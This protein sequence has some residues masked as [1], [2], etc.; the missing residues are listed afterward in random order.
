MAKLGPA[1]NQS[2][3]DSRAQTTDGALDNLTQ[4]VNQMRVDGQQQRGRGRGRGRG[5]GRGGRGDGAHRGGRRQNATQ[6]I[7]VPKEDYDFDAANAKFNKQ[8]LV[9][10]AIATGSPVTSPTKTNGTV[11]NPLENGHANGAEADAEDVVI[12]AASE[13]GYDK[14]SSFFDNISS[15]LKDRIEQQQSEQSFDGRAMRNQERSRNVETFGQ[16]SVDN[17]GYRGSRG[18]G[19]GRG[20]GRGGRGYSGEGQRG[21]R[22]LP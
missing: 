14:K 21:A 17:G 3:N 8:D 19:R 5:E 1:N 11:A 13:K 10:E 9:K 6:A 20:Y 15:D 22:A 2:R 4:K 7:D 18:R 16:G 12:P